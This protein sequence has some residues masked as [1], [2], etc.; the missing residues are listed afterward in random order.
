MQELK[1][2]KPIEE[3]SEKEVEL[4]KIFADQEDDRMDD[5]INY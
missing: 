3:L 5:V 2:D 1:I 4:I